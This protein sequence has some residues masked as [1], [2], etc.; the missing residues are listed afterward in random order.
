MANSLY[1]PNASE[2]GRP[3]FPRL[4]FLDTNVVQNL[5]TFG[6][7]IYDNDLS[8][9]SE[10]KLSRLGPRT[11]DDV[12][13]LA[14]LM[15]L[16]RRGGLP[17]VIS[18]RTRDELAATPNPVKRVRLDLWGAD[19]DRY[20][21]GLLE[22]CADEPES[23]R[24]VDTD[25]LTARQRCFMAELLAAMPDEGDRQLMIDALLLRCDVFLTMDYKS[26]WRVRDDVERFGIRI[27]RPVELVAEIRPRAGLMR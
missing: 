17:I 12:H 6:E 5:A 25:V 23:R 2:H 14:E 16:G 19:L 27:L 9:E 22:A 7:F 11:A 15:D 18:P 20:S 24:P 4:I 21:S 10:E 3:D 26:I 8:P 1:P 13:A